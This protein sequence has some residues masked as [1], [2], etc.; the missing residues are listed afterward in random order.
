MRL[1][2][3]PLAEREGPIQMRRLILPVFALAL[4]SPVVAQTVKIDTG[5]LQGA[6]VDAISSFKNIPYAAPPVGALR[7]KPPQPA[8]RWADVRDAAHYG[9]LCIQ[10]A[11]KDNGVGPGPASEDCLQLNV[12]SPSLKAKQPVM[13]WIHGGGFTNGSGTAALYDGAA[14]AKQGVVVVT[15]NY[16]LGRFGFFAHPALT[17]EGGPLANYA[18]MDMVAGLKWV[19]R[20]ISAFGGD[21]AQVTI[22]GESAGGIAINQLMLMPQARGLFARAITESGLGREPTGPLAAAE[23]K[24]AAFAEKLGVRADQPDAAAALRALAADEV[25]AAGDPNL[26]LGDMPIADGQMIM[27]SP[28]DGF[29]QGH[30]AKVAFIVGSNDIEL[31]KAYGGGY[32]KATGGLSQADEDQMVEAYGSREA[33]ET[34]FKSDTIFTEPGRTLARLHASRGAPTWTYRFSILSAG[35][36][37]FLPG[38]PHAQERQYLFQN[39]NASPWPT[40]GRDQ[41]LAKTV[42]AYWTSFAKTGSPNGEG[43]PTWPTYDDAQQMI[44]FTNDGPIVTKVSDAAAIALI[45]QR[46]SSPNTKK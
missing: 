19:K 41:Q 43:R 10:V 12:T 6:T 22:F 26:S 13:V 45:A 14:L 5:R 42:S 16:R 4:A 35:A 20:N 11:S 28:V 7:W 8:A 31:P 37:K 32:T 34:R 39:L 9:P 46:A 25:L 2:V 15:I 1:F 27:G 3:L 30:Q 21:P 33:F 24:G 44:D 38:T 23:A 40:D 18:M 17:K 29:A 36:P